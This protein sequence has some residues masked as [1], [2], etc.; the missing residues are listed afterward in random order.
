MPL[1]FVGDAISLSGLTGTKLKC[2]V[3]GVYY[4]FWWKITSG[5]KAKQY[6]KSTAIVELDAAT[7]EDYIKETGETV[8]GSAGHALELK[9]SHLDEPDVDTSN[10]KV[11]LIERNLNCYELLKKV[12]KRRWP[13]VSIKEAEGSFESNSSNIYLFNKNL[14]DALGIIEDLKL[15][16]AIYYFDPLRSVQWATIEKVASRRIKDVFQTGTDF[17]I[18][19]FTSDWFLGRDDFGPLPKTIEEER[20]NKKQKAT[21]ADAD[22]FFGNQEWRKYVLNAQPIQAR[23]KVFVRLYKMNLYRWFRYVLPMPFAPKVNQLFHLILC[24]NYEVGVK[25]TR[26]FYAS[27]TDNPIYLPGRLPQSQAY[28]MFK[29]AHPETLKGLKGNR[30]PLQWRILWKTIKYHEGGICDFL[31]KDFED[32]EPDLSNVQSALQWLLTNNYFELLEIGNAWEYPINRYRL[33]WKVIKETLNVDPPPELKPISPEEFEKF[34]WR[35]LIEALDSKE[36]G[37]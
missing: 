24:S 17:I 16:N 14:D 33:N 29:K 28:S 31:C 35:K 2:D 34:Q 18:F 23:Q 9:V 25:M 4:P 26:D 36:E 20:W 32:I 12:I 27:R 11:V 13:N 7:G 30:R 8:L 10:L 22:A 1:E 15:G 37:N 5:G 3:I 6:Q 19:S 21:V